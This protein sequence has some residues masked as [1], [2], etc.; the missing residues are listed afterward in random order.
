MTA[1][2]ES[3]RVPAGWQV[4]RPEELKINEKYSLIGGPF[5]SDLTSQ[6]YVEAPGIPVI[7]GV[8]LG[9][10]DSRFIDDGFVFVSEE[11]ASSLARNMAYPGDLVFTQR[12]T[13]G[14]V[15]LIPKKSRFPRY[16]ISQSQMKAT[17]DESKAEPRYLWHFF[18]SPIATALLKRRALATGVPHINLA[19]LKEFPVI[20]PPRVDQ[21]RIAAILDK[22]DALR[23]K[24]RKAS[25][26]TA[27][28]ALSVV[29]ETFGD[30]ARNDRGWPA[31]TVADAGEVQLGRQRAPHYQTGQ[32]TRPYLRVANVFEDR[33]DLSDVLSMDFDAD[34]FERYQLQAEDIL[35][36]EGQSTELVGRPAVWRDEIPNCCFQNTLIRFRADRRKTEPEYALAVFLAYLRTGVFARASSKTSS[37]AHLGAGRFAALPFPLPPLQ[38][39][40]EFVARKRA[41]RE[42]ERKQQRAERQADDLFNSLVQRA[43][44]GEL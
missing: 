37:V 32:F 29:G 42:L 22:A 28:L 16:I 18:R 40:R 12:G 9:G 14:Q 19:I 33:L 17:I 39:Q 3:S 15:G 24:R 6:D 34:D 7:R 4:V 26:I 2:R 30:L 5:G 8:N 31:V 41:M 44:R 43:F 11:K 21:E 10:K 36:N 20:L 25:V 1:A 23:R 27:S 13:L 38:L 35:L